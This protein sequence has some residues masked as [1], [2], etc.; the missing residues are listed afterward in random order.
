MSGMKEQ[1]NALFPSFPPPPPPPCPFPLLSSPPFLPPPV[2]SSLLFLLP[3][4]SSLP[5][6]IN[7]KLVMNSS[8][9]QSREHATLAG[10]GAVLSP[11]E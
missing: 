2:P 8:C 1:E 3:S 4:S 6:K 10:L 9:S 11:F 7:T 5:L